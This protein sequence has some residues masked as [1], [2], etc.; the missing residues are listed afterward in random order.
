MIARDVG[1]E[2]LPSY[3]GVGLRAPHV[4]EV[5]ATRPAV[6]FFEVHPENYMGGGPALSALERVRLDHAVSLHGVGL[7]L[8]GAGALDR[9]HLTRLKAL[10]DRLQPVLV[11]EHLA[12]S[13]VGGTYLNH[14]LPLPY[15]DERLDETG[16]R[17]ACVQET[18]GR[19]I[20]VE[21]PSRYLRFRHSPIPEPEFLSELARRTGCGIL[22]DVNNVYVSSHNV[23]EN[24]LAYLAAL[25]AGAIGEIHLAG[26]AT[27]H[28]EGR[29][30]LIDDHGSRVSEP[31]W[32]L[33]RRA[34][35]RLGPVATLVEW[36]TNLPA[37]AVLL[38]EAAHAQ[39]ILDA[40]R[41]RERDA[42][43]A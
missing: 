41:R 38:G 5:M 12:W 21:N 31:V 17:V 1:V 30:I 28:A 8:A 32:E 18:L 35:A 6:A 2:T 9:R 4:A 20:L 26:H 7:S 29:A 42:V 33:Y 24:P 14:L 25:P 27:N 10:V 34:L 36:D 23:D 39:S 15:D 3:A 11:S 13:A 19:T 16:R 40:V 37:L 22:L 43:A